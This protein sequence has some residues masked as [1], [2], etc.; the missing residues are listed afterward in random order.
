MARLKSGPDTKHQSRDS[1]KTRAFRRFGSIHTLGNLQIPSARLNWLRKRAKE[2]TSGPKGL[3]I[4]LDLCTAEARTYLPIPSTFSPHLCWVPR[5]R[6][7]SG[8]YKSMTTCGPWAKRRLCSPVVS[9]NYLRPLAPGKSRRSVSGSP[10]ALHR[11][12]SQPQGPGS[13][14]I[15]ATERDA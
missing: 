8:P 3:M 5:A 4:L 2:R 15:R 6:L 1:G 7:K 9:E 12:H 11:S 14:P 13:E 10:A